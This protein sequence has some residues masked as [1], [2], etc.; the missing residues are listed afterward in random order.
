MTVCFPLEIAPR[1]EDPPEPQRKVDMR[2]SS[3]S[4]VQIII[5]Q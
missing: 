4:L 3:S 1:V 2:G 5:P